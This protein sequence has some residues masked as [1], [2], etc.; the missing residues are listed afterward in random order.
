MKT[1]LDH[2]DLKAI[3][4]GLYSMIPICVL[5]TTLL[6]VTITVPRKGKQIRTSSFCRR[7]SD[8][9]FPYIWVIFYQLRIDSF[10]LKQ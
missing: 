9:L 6:N 8:L 5:T 2:Y 1:K 10:G 7:H 4:N 3:V